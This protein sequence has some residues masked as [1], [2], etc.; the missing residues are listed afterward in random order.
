VRTARRLLLPLVLA[1]ALLATFASGASAAV[2]SIWGPT[3][4]FGGCGGS[5]FPLYDQL[6]VDNVQFQI[7]WDTVARS[8]PANPRNPNDPAYHWP[9]SGDYMVQQAARYGISVAVLVQG[10]PSWANGGL[11]RAYVPLNLRDYADFVFAI[12]RRYPTIHRW[13]IWGEPNYGLNFQ[14]MP[15][16][17]RVG[18]RTYAKLLDLAYGALK[19]AS[20]KN[21]VIGGMTI[22]GGGPVST[23]SFVKWLRVGRGKKARPPRMDLWGHNPFDGRVPNVKKKPIGKFRGLSDVDT[24]HREIER[25]Y[26]LRAKRKG[27]KA[28]VPKLWLSEWTVLSEPSPNLFGGFHVSPEQQAAY[29]TG[30]YRMVRKLKYVKALG[31]Y[32]LE[33]QADTGTVG[34][35]WGLMTTA[36]DWKPSFNAYAAAR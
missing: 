12:S 25:A 22:S 21:V 31:W 29:V 17:S 6:G 26:G 30:A 13:M 4:D 20:R 15:P 14:P 8:R 5:C 33:D 36:G 28:R 2:K 1:G 24:L 7:P 35:A 27:K 34:A 16:N 23:P 11:P 3:G 32:R 9:A 10:T 19:R 18:P